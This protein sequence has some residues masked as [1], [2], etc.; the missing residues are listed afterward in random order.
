MA[1]RTDLISGLTECFTDHR[2]QRLIEYTVKEWLG[3]C[4]YGLCLGYEDLNDHDQLRADP[5]LAIVVD[6]AD[7]LGESRR[8]AGDRGKALAG[9]C[10]LNRLELTG[11]QVDGQERYKK[12]AMD[13]DKIDRWMVDAFVAAPEFAPEEIVLDL[14]ATDDTIH[15]HQEG[16]FYHGYYGNY[17]YLPLYIFSGEHRATLKRCVKAEAVSN[18]PVESKQARAKG[19]KEGVH[20]AWDRRALER[21]N[22]QGFASII[23]RSG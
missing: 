15:G 6:K 18:L 22:S 7:P 2:D 19:P 3:Q 1:K 10:T 20:T 8:Q 11:A 16:R 23:W 9:K 21:K 17:C 13:G 5:M 14:D 4:I 12:L